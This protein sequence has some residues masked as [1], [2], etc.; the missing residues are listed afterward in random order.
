MQDNQPIGEYVSS[1]TLKLNGTQVFGPSDFNQNVYFITTQVTL[2]AI[3]TLDVTLKGKPGGVITVMILGEESGL[4]VITASI[5]PPANGTGW[6]HTEATVSFTCSDTL[7]GIASCHGPVA[8][9]TEGANQTVTGTAVDNAGNT[10]TTAA[11]VNLDK[12]APSITA[13]ADRNANAAGWYNGPVTVSFACTDG[14]SGIAACPTP[15]VMNADGA[16]QAISGTA[17]DLADNAASTTLAINLD[18]TAPVISILSP[19]DGAALSVNPPPITIHYSD[20]LALD[21]NRL[22]LAVNGQA[23]TAQ[24]TITATSA[25]CI[26]DIALTGATVTLTAAISDLA[27]NTGTSP[28]TWNLDRDGDGV[29]DADDAFPDD[30]GEWADQDSDGIGDNSDPDRDGD[31]FDNDVELQVGTDPNDAASV[32]VDA[33]GNGIPD[34]LEAPPSQSTLTSY[35]S[36]GLIASVDGPRTDVAD[37]TTFDYDAQGNLIRITN[38]LG[39]VTEITAHDAHG[40]PLTIIDPNGTVTELAYDAR[41]RVLTR[42]TDGAT[43]TFAYDG[44]GN[45]TQ[46]TLPNGSL[47]RQYLRCR[48]AP[49]GHRGQPGQPHRLHPGCPGQPCRGK[50]QRSAWHP[51]PD[52]RPYLQHAQP[53]HPEHRR[54]RAD[55]H[56]RL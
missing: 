3:N 27:G 41:G 16:Q 6:H 29:P 31:G 35:N 46:T 40:R 44:V 56:L 21:T 14:L 13:Q 34:V 15:A 49:D 1:S 54:G 10:A 8:V 43:T 47:P 26:P 5:D 4:P 48:P 17:T 36:L 9:T 39:H 22:S 37:I 42:T 25:L 52:T 20:N 28:A 19:A 53:P 50:R 45:V 7:S 55:D 18:Q 32:P 38:A 11:T 23:I 12:T 2:Q 30:P 51:D 33:N 24:C